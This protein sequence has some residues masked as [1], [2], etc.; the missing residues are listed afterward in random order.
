[1]TYDVELRNDGTQTITLPW[2]AFPPDSPQ[3]VESPTV[4]P[5]MAFSLAVGEGLGGSLGHW[6]MLYGDTGDPA[7]LRLLRPGSSV[8]IRAATPCQFTSRHAGKLIAP[9]GE[10]S[11]TVSARV[12]LTRSS[13]ELGAFT[14]SNEL[15]LSVSRW[16]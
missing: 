4:F 7:S 3:P 11:V 10:V 12:H 14:N 8:T 1:V 6:E 13:D 2:S 16:R 5:I 15:L 9:G